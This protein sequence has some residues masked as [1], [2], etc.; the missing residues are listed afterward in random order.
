[1]KKMRKESNGVDFGAT[2]SGGGGGG[3][4]SKKIERVELVCSDDVNIVIKDS[5]TPLTYD[6]VK[7]LVDDTTKFVTLRYLDIWWMLPSYDDGGAIM[8]TSTDITNGH[9]EV[10]RVVMNTE[11]QL[12]NYTIIIEDSDHKTDDLTKETA[13]DGHFTYPTT[14]AVNQ[15][16][17][18]LD[19]KVGDL[20]KL[21]T[22]AK[23]NLVD[24]INEAAQGGGGGGADLSKATLVSSFT[25]TEDVDQFEIPISEWGLYVFQGEFQ[26]NEANAALTNSYNGLMTHLNN[27]NNSDPIAY[28]GLGFNTFIGGIQ[29]TTFSVFLFEDFSVCV[30]GSYVSWN[31][32]YMQTYSNQLANTARFVFHR[33]K[34]PIKLIFNQSHGTAKFMSGSK[35][36]LYKIG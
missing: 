21:E 32:Y 22:E 9:A 1:M 13:A 7:S 10:T 26:G 27:V 17:T 33:K 12:S 3:D 36:N 18:A 15:G 4:V 5:D 29:T 30:N 35:I 19:L 25:L 11:G 20:A 23:D 16:L 34:E 6:D 8:F 24:A 28:T 31:S 2:V 14:H